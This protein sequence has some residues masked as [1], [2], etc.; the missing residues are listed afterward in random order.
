MAEETGLEADAAHLLGVRT[1]PSIQYHS[2]LMVG[3]FVNTY[4]GLMTAGDDAE[5]VEWFQ[6]GQLPPIAFESHQYFIQRQLDTFDKGN[7]PGM[8]PDP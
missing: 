7:S 1:T 6:P 2:V 3:Y 5:R 4:R 8:V